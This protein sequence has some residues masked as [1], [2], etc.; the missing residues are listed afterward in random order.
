MVA[1]KI[2]AAMCSLIGTAKL[3]GVDPGSYALR[4]AKLRN[5]D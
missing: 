3:N 4:S 1:E 2:P 5:S